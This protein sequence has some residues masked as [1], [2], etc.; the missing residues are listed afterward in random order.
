MAVTHLP[1]VDVNT[2]QSN[3]EW[4]EQAYSCML[5]DT[6][7]VRVLLGLRSHLPI[8]FLAGLRTRW[9]AHPLTVKW[10]R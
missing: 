3:T 2:V 4:S 6:H 1:D 5:C 8:P 9:A 10:T 7:Q